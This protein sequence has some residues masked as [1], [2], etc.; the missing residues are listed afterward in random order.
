MA[1]CFFAAA[2]CALA[3]P[4]ASDAHT[5]PLEARAVRDF[6]FVLPAATSAPVGSGIA[7][8][9]PGAERFAV[10]AEGDRL[11]VDLDGDGQ[12][13]GLVEGEEGFITLVHKSEDGRELSYSALLTRRPGQPWRYSYGGVRAGKFGA[14]KLQFVDQDLNGRFD[15]FGRDALVVGND[16]AAGFL[17]RVVSIAGELWSLEVAA[18]G[19]SCTL[20]P[21]RGDVGTID[22]AG[23][24]KCQAKLQAAV[25]VS[26]DGQLSFSVARA[27]EGLRVPA[28]SYHLHSGQIVLAEARA[29]IRGDA[30]SKIQVDSGAVARPAWGGPVR[31]EFAAARAGNQLELAPWDI[32]YY[33]ALGEEYS[34]FMPLGKSPEFT[35][36]D[37]KSG[38]VL[39]YARFP[40]N[41]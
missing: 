22:L 29:T 23:A 6:A 2:L 12:C 41:C 5:V 15:D 21:F 40:G 25:V 4:S 24:F 32:W 28:G 38:E 33:G 19:M 14:T 13:E 26:D 17:S 27:S 35:L 30:R 36:R 11:R 20:S 3:S 18:D 9:R 34:N 37:R 16:C 10:Q 7:F 31:A 8:P 1:C 39:V